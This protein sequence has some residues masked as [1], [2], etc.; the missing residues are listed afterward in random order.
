MRLALILTAAAVIVSG[1]GG[2][3]TQTVTSVKTV[4]VRR[5]G[6]QATGHP[7]VAKNLVATPQIT[8]ELLLAWGDPKVKGPLPGTTYL[9]RYGDIRYAVAVFD[10]PVTGTTDQPE[11]LVQLPGE[12]WI[13]VTEVGGGPL[14]EVR[15]VPCPL[16]KVWGFGC[17]ENGD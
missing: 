9:G 3:A 7:L 14:S 17:A 10:L 5:S 13:T 2:S 4:K 1:C 8:H 6:S 12:F 16:R 11:L 15:A